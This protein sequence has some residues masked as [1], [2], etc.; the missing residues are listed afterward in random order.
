MEEVTVTTFSNTKCS[1]RE[2]RSD[3][4]VGVRLTSGVGSIQGGGLGDTSAIGTLISR[5]R[6]IEDTD[7]KSKRPVGRMRGMGKFGVKEDLIR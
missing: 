3:L 6:S 5:L 2:G 7:L 4:E 1:C